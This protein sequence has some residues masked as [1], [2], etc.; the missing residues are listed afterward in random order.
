MIF[1]YSLHI[2]RGRY[3]LDLTSE[4]PSLPVTAG[5]ICHSVNSRLLFRQVDISH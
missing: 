3:R 2:T 5:R 4:L 1:G